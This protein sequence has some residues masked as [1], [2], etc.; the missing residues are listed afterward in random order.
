MKLEINDRPVGVGKKIGPL[1]SWATPMNGLSG[2]Q[3]C[4]FSKDSL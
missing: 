2:D 4:T 1:Q 3:E